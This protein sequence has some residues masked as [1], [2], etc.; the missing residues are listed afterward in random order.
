MDADAALDFALSDLVLALGL[1]RPDRTPCGQPLSVSE[2]LTL[3]ALDVTGPLVQRDLAFA[4][5]L[6]KSTVSRLVDGLARRGF[7]ERDP[8]P[9]DGRQ[10]LVGLTDV[11]R[12]QVTALRATRTARMAGLLAAVPADQRDAVVKAVRLLVEAGN[13]TR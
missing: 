2:G 13:A 8:H 12:R 5:K 4:L 6:E 9:Q 7:V 11:G 10:L 1:H 3:L